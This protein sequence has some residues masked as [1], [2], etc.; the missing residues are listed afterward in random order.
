MLVVD[1]APGKAQ[2]WKWHQWVGSNGPVSHVDLW[3]EIL[4]LL[5]ICGNEV[6]WLQVPS[7]VGIKGNHKADELAD[8]GRRKS[9]L[10]FGHISVNMVGRVQVEEDGE[11]EFDEQSLLGDEGEPADVE[12]L[13]APT[14]PV[15]QTGDALSTPV[16]HTPRA[17]TKRSGGTP[18]MDVEACMLLRLNKRSNPPPPPVLDFEPIYSIRRR[19]VR[20]ASETP[21]LGL[22][23]FQTPR[24][25]GPAHHTSRMP[26]QA[27]PMS[28]EALANLATRPNGRCA[29]H[30]AK[31]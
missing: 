12:D 21:Q 31:V 18:L 3:E 19:L 22:G 1:G 15:R 7:H 8:V 16:R 25:V 13:V 23:Q 17:P 26:L 29:P 5:E 24:V 20:S 10:L 14:T 4:S 30:P 6:R 11:E 2:K 27:S 28:P 9:P